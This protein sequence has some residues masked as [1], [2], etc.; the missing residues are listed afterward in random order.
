M[1]KIFFAASFSITILA[2]S[3]TKHANDVED[4]TPQATIQFLSPLA[5]AVYRNGDSVN[6]K[7]TAI[8]TATIH[9]CDLIIRKA[10]DTAK[11]YF[12]HIHDHNT[13]LQI[14][15]KWKADISN[16]S[17]EVEIVLYLDHEGHTATKRTAFRMQ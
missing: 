12:N 7:A 15:S 8:S 6:I 13:T 16:A 11:I 9:G 4:T 10:N 1:K 5:G 2:L 3:C 17:M 14:D